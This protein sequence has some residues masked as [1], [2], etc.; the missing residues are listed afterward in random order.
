MNDLQNETNESSKQTGLRTFWDFLAFVAKTQGVIAV[1]LLYVICIEQPSNRDRQCAA[2]EEVAAKHA[3]A[4]SSVV[5]AFRD[6]QNK[7]HDRN[8]E[9]IR[10]V[11][12][13]R[14]LAGE[15]KSAENLE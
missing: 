14:G 9:L 1:I 6:E 15:L 7:C 5:Q 12:R 13:A 3:E 11:I 10:D 4:M 2:M 8:Q